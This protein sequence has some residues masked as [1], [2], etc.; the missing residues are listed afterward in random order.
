MPDKSYYDPLGYYFDN[1]GYDTVGGKYDDH[2]F[3]IPP[4]NHVGEAAYG[5]D[6]EDYTLDEDEVD[7]PQLNNDD[8]DR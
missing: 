1:E 3:Y 5:E 4:S 7:Q 2:G 8:L 6:L